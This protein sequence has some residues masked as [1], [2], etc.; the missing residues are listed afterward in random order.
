MIS[1]FLNIQA[2]INYTY[3][4]SIAQKLSELPPS[5]H[6]SSPLDVSFQMK[7]F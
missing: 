5:S 4:Y 3:I 2:A 6:G 7:L 1:P